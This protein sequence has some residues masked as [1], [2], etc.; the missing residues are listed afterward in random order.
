MQAFFRGLPVVVTGATGFIGSHLVERLVAMG[1]RVRCLVRR[2][3]RVALLPPAVELAYGDLATGEGIREAVQG[4]EVVFHL[5]GVTKALSRAEFYRGNVVATRNLVQALGE[6]CRRLVHTSS[7]AATGPSPKGSPLRE[8]VE[9]R[10]LTHYGRSKLEAECAVRSSA[11]AGRA[12]IVRPPVVFGPRDTDVLELFRMIVRGWLLVTGDPQAKF[13]VIYVED[14]VEGL[15]AAA[16]C[17]EAAGRI[18]FLAAPEPLSWQGL[19]VITGELIGRRARIMKVPYPVA[20]L[21]AL[22]WEV[23]SRWRRR[24]AIISREK[25]REARSG[26]WQCDPGKASRELGFIARTSHREA[27][28]RTLRWYRQAGW[29]QW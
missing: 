15:L 23:A 22:G 11:V 28:A 7:L 10:P 29:L 19:A 14:L 16:S 12:V 24:P 21:A 20:W 26:G 6:N 25:L 17:S 27:I 4:A 3:S 18:Y 13:S 9:P 1:A 2:T 5:A 8:E